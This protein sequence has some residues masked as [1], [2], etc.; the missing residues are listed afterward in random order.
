LVPAVPPGTY[1]LHVVSEFQVNPL[2]V[3][4]YQ[5]WSQPF[6]IVER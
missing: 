6:Q 1:K 3:V 2:R 5:R 4:R